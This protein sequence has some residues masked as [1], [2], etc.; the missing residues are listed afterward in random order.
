M[1]DSPYLNAAPLTPNKVQAEDEL[2]EDEIAA[3]QGPKLRP[4]RKKSVPLWLRLEA[5]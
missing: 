2:A 1:A 3:T 4:P 5:Q